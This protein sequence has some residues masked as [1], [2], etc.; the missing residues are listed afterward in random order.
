MNHL[1]GK[2][3]NLC[4]DQVCLFPYP[5]IEQSGIS[6]LSTIKVT[7][8]GRVLSDEQPPLQE[9]AI[10]E[11]EVHKKAADEILLVDP[12]NLGYEDL[13]DDIADVGTEIYTVDFR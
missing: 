11:V 1:K 3:K 7:P 10:N 4:F 6:W 9:D 5:R 8:R 2:A 12:Q 13:P